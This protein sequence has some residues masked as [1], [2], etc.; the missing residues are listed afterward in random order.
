MAIKISEEVLH[1]I[2]KLPYVKES[3]IGLDESHYPAICLD[4]NQHYNTGHA[5]KDKMDWS[6]TSIFIPDNWTDVGIA[7]DRADPGYIIPMHRDHF[8]N[9]CIRFNHPRTRVKRRLVFIEDWKDGHY[10][11]LGDQVYHNWS[12][13]DYVEWGSESRHMGA[14]VGSQP[15]YTCQVTGVENE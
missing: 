1:R 13:G 4:Q 3:H 15:R 11:Q 8:K 5:K 12:Q 14:N 9:Y 2:K 6:W 7:F 10:F